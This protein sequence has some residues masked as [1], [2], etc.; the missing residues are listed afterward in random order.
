MKKAYYSMLN[1]IIRQMKVNGQYLIDR[2]DMEKYLDLSEESRE[3]VE[4]MCKKAMIG[5]ML[6]QNNYRSCVRGQGVFIDVDALKSKSIANML[7]Q[8]ESLTVNQKLA[9]VQKL[10]SIA[11]GLPDDGYV[12]TAF[13]MDGILYEEMTKAELINLIHELQGQAVNE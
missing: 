3:D 10:K 5:V 7:V 1:A 11:D 13:D 2:T 8:N 4:D 6:Y 12:Q 9:A